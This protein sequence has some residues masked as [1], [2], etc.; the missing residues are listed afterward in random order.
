MQSIQEKKSVFTTTVEEMKAALTTCR[1][2]RYPA[3]TLSKLI[4]TFFHR[5][6]VE[7]GGISA[8]QSVLLLTISISKR[9]SD[10]S[11]KQ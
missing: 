8:S 9:S 5:I 3:P 2:A 11:L 7:L 1:R 6:S 10:V 4:F